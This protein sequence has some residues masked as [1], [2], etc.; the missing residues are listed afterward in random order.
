M[1]PFFMGS[2]GT[3]YELHVDPPVSALSSLPNFDP[4]KI[5]VVG[6]DH[7]LPP[8][9]STRLT[10]QA[11]RARFADPPHWEPEVRR[12]PKFTNRHPAAAAVLIPIICRPIPSVLLTQ[13]THHLPTHAGQIAFPGGKVDASDADAV[14]A[15]LREAFEEVGLAARHVEVLGCLSEYVTGTAFHI[16]PVVGLVAPEF[17]L[18]PNPGEVESVFEVP[19][20]FLMSPASHRRHAMEVNGERREWFSMPYVPPTP[21]EPTERFIWGATAGILRNLYRF[22]RA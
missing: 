15:A 7:H 3:P 1:R 14:A 17:E 13:R 20:Q 10:P 6:V 5:A 22:L 16:T 4:R 12:E 11:L 21:H 19:L 18:A 2:S 9:E 8:V